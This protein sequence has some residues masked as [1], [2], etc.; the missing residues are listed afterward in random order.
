MMTKE[1]IFAA[2]APEKSPWSTW[3]KPVLFAHF[4]EEFRQ[5]PSNEVRL[6]VS[7]VP[8]AGERCALVLDLPGDEGVWVGASLAECGYQPVPLYNAIPQPVHFLALNA[9]TNL[10]I[11]AVNVFPILSA[12]QLAAVRLARTSIPPTAPPAFLLDANRHGGGNRPIEGMFDNRSVCFT[13]DF[14]SANILRS[15]G[16]DRVLLVQRERIEPQDDLAHVLRRW[17][18]GGLVLERM[19]IEVPVSRGRFQAARPRWYGTMFQRA[20]VAVGLRR[21]PSGGFGAWMPTS[22]AG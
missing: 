10:A 20:L 22:S 18:D 3:A 21:A 6:D 19:Q 2:W 7:W 17:Q 11:G 14:P 1:E 4:R 15:K 12:L 16:I 9:V 5:P 13:T 8:S